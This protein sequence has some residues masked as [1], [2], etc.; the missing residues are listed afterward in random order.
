[1]FFLKKEKVNIKNINFSLLRANHFCRFL[2]Q[3]RFFSNFTA[4]C[5]DITA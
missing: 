1:M 3:L 2:Q 4:L 5:K